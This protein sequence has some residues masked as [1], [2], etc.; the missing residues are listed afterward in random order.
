MFVHARLVPVHQSR[1]KSNVTPVWASCCGII[2][3]VQPKNGTQ[4]SISIMIYLVEFKRVK[5]EQGFCIARGRTLD[6][7]GAGC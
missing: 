1:P 4:L 6:R 5:V 2:I 7:G 3:A